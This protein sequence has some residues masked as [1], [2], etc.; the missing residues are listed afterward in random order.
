MCQF[1]VSGPDM[2]AYTAAS[3]RAALSPAEGGKPWDVRPSQ[4]RRLAGQGRGGGGVVAGVSRARAG[5]AH[6]GEA[7]AVGLLRACSG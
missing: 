5:R 1:A 2:H 3:V 7:V 4:V 6:G